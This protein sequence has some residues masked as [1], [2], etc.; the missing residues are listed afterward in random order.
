MHERRFHS[1][2]FGESATGRFEE[3]DRLRHLDISSADPVTVQGGGLSLAGAGFGSGTRV[4]GM[5]AFDRILDFDPDEGRI[6]VEAGITLGKLFGFLMPRGWMV[7]VQPGY[8]GVTVGGCIAGNV[9]GK[10]QYKEGCFGDWVEAMTLY[11]PRHGTIALSAD[12]EPDLFALTI[13]GYGLTG[14]IRAARLRLRPAD[15]TATRIH[16]LPVA[17][18]HEAAAMLVR[19]RDEA[20][21]MYSWHD[22]A[23]PTVGRGLVFV[24][25]AAPDASFP[26]AARWPEFRQDRFAAPMGLMN[27]ASLGLMNTAY[28]RM[29][30]RA[31]TLS[32]WDA[33]FPFA[34][35]VFY[36]Y[37]YGRRGFIEHQVLIP[38]DTA[39][40]Y[41][42]RLKAAQRRHGV[43]LGL[44]T[45]KLFQGSPRWL[46]FTGE[47]ISLA[48][49]APNGR[50]AQ[51]FFAEL[52]TLDRE[53][54]AKANVLKDARLPREALDAQYP[55]VQDF[56]DQLR[57][58]DPDRMFRSALSERLGL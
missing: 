43:P 55:E 7:A 28:R 19:Q 22:M 37:L 35:K 2:G 48:V 53:L 41:L 25:N 24:G 30:A 54:G 36:F 26:V 33:S 16:P 11:H 34:S 52:D 20:D 14:I 6:E 18:L 9:H 57:Q 21:F 8:P 42:D 45:L 27:R 12:S 44:A 23:A 47:G 5:R 40:T 46:R 3:P 31:R 1:V 49:E 32:Y 38:L 39:D 4:I 15:G 56:R 58:F 50:R 51:A 17:D 29:N 10:S 13:G